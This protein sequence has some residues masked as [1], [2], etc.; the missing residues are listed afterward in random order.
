MEGSCIVSKDNTIYEIGNKKIGQ[1]KLVKSMIIN[2][3]D[4][5]TNI[6]DINFLKVPSI[7]NNKDYISFW[8]REDLPLL[9]IGRY[10]ASCGIDSKSE[11][12]Y[13]F[14]GIDENGTYLDSIE[15]ININNNNQLNKQWIL[16]KNTT[17]YRPRARSKVSIDCINNILLLIKNNFISPSS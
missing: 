4:T 14:G 3:D 13:V 1:N 16:L 5:D 10:Y 17:L 8:N 9:N 12:L 15:N 6:I 7:N 11:Y 2:T